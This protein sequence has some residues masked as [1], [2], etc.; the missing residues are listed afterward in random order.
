MEQY[1]KFV[2][3]VYLEYIA[4]GI[5]PSEELIDELYVIADVSPSVGGEAVFI[6]R[7][8][9]NY[10]PEQM[11]R[12]NIVIPLRINSATDHVQLYP[13]PASDDLNVLSLN[14]PFAPGTTIELFDFVG[15]KAITAFVSEET[16]RITISLKDLKQ[17]IYLCVIKTGV[18]IISTSKISVI[19]Q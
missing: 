9:L 6:A 3:S 4:K 13:N 16:D 12:D 2:N 17:G 7:A 5:V 11:H 14:E 10:S 19:K 15:K 1:R 8:I 18:E